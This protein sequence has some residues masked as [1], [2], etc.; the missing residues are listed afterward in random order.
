VG[1]FWVT[2]GDLNGV[3]VSMKQN[4]QSIKE[5]VENGKYHRLTEDEKNR[6]ERIRTSDH[7]N[8]IQVVSSKT[9]NKIK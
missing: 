3:M 1:D 9:L 2:Q 6:A 8:P 4:R 7:L 5:G